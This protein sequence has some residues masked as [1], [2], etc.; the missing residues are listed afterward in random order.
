MSK[1]SAQIWKLIK[2]K[3]WC[4]VLN[5]FVVPSDFHIV[6]LFFFNSN[7]LDYSKQIPPCFVLCLSFFSER[8]LRDYAKNFRETAEIIHLG[9]SP[10]PLMKINI[11]KGY[12]RLHLWKKL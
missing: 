12:H 6:I 4:S 5:F 11:S 8:P 7:V 2:K 9:R 1:K 3:N 10:N